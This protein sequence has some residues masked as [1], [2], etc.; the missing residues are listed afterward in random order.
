MAAG[1]SVHVILDNYATHKTPDVEPWLR[2]HPRVH[3]H[4]TPTSASWLTLV[5]LLFNELSRR[6]LRRLAANSVAELLAA[7]TAYSV[8]STPPDTVRLDR[9]CHVHSRERLQ[10]ESHF[11]IAPLA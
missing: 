11:S 8:A 1:L 5:E 7:I 3:F 4:F 10:C 2:R 9:V 6:Q